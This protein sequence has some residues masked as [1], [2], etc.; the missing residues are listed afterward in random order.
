[1]TRLGEYEKLYQVLRDAL[2]FTSV[3]QSSGPL[4]SPPIVRS[5]HD[6]IL[7]PILRCNSRHRPFKGLN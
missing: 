7:R 2:C 1:M 4:A 6:T 3:I 5:R